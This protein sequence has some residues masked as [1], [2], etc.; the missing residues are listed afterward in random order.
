MSPKTKVSILFL[1]LAFPYM[2]FVLFFALKA[3]P[4]ST[5]PFPSWFP[6]VALTY[7]LTS[8][9]LAS[10]L[11]PRFFRNASRPPDAQAGGYLRIA[12]GQTLYLVLL[13]SGLFIYGAYKTL[14][15]DLPIERALPAGAFLLAFIGLFAW[16]GRRMRAAGGQAKSS[17]P[18]DR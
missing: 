4:G 6:W 3:A 1:G 17:P 9:L 18:P 13:W 12:E 2:L 5:H 7:M 16:S 8:I 10:V 15:G 11:T 14:H